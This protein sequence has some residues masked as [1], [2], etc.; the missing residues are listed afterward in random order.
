MD[1]A[2]GCGRRAMGCARLQGTGE[3]HLDKYIKL[4][5]LKPCVLDTCLYYR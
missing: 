5:N 3:A 1:T 4:L 2:S